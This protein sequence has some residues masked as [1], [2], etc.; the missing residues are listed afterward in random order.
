MQN[1]FAR[2]TVL[3]IIGAGFAVTGD[4]THIVGQGRRLIE[5]ADI[6][7]PAEPADEEAPEPVPAGRPEPAPAAASDPKRPAA[8]AASPAV[9]GSP[10]ADD[11]RQPFDHRPPV[12]GP[13]QLDVA[14][15]PAGARLTLWLRTPVIVA[16]LRL[17]C[18]VIDPATGEVLVHAGQ[19]GPAARCVML[20]A[21][22]RPVAVLARDGSVRVHRL[23]A[24][25]RPVPEPMAAG[26]IIALA[27]GP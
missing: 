25:G 13:E 8:N 2:C 21:A 27:E 11:G 7:T 24:D 19:A 6:P 16:P 23:G 26:S 9:A 5:A 10:P 17:V 3:A 12:T 4:L 18:D 22:G 15:M 1:F 20:A 14:G